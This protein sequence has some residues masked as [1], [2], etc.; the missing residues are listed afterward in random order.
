[1]HIQLCIYTNMT[2]QFIS[3]GYAFKNYNTPASIACRQMLAIVAVLD[4]SE[5]ISLH[6]IIC[7]SVAKTLAK[8]P[9]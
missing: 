9:S 4:G 5:D 8:L 6:K 3:W 1:M 2:N 7:I